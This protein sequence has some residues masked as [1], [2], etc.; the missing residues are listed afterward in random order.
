M[1]QRWRL[2]KQFLLLVVLLGCV[3]C[4][5]TAET[6]RPVAKNIKSDTMLVAGSGSNLALTRRLAAEYSRQ[7]GQRIDIPGSIGTVGAV[8]AVQEGAIPLGLTSRPLKPEERAQGLKQ[9]HYASIGLAIAAPS[10]VPDTEMNEQ[11]LIRIYSE[12]KP[13]WENGA[14]MVVLSMYE[15]D[16]TNEVLLK[17]IPGF[18]GALKKALARKDWRTLYSEGSMLETLLKTPNSIGFIDAVALVKNKDKLRALDF[19]GI[20]MNTENILTGRYRL[21]KDLYFIYK[22]TLQFS[23][24]RFVEYCFSAEGRKIIADN[25]AVPVPWSE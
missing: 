20:R 12:E 14:D 4:G 19:G 8:K 10:A 7:S 11:T 18:E 9:I 1:K 17:Q 22:D 3:G 13:T 2:G 23:A 6:P 15:G 16:S 25:G 5:Q 24:K 21:K